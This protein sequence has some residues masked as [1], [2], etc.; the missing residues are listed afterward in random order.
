MQLYMCLF[1]DF[2]FPL[3]ADGK[4]HCLRITAIGCVLTTL[5]VIGVGLLGGSSLEFDTIQGNG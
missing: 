4:N 5:S 3:S 1:G 2:K